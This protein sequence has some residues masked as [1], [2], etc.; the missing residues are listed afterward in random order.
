VFRPCTPT[1]N[2]LET[3]KSA[4]G[5]ILSGQPRSSAWRILARANSRL[6]SPGAEPRSGIVCVDT[7][8]SSPRAAACDRRFTLRHDTS[9]LA[10]PARRPIA[11]RSAYG[12]HTWSLESARRRL[13]STTAAASDR[14]AGIHPGRHRPRMGPGHLLTTGAVRR[15]TPSTCSKESDDIFTRSCD[16]GTP[17]AT[18]QFHWPSELLPLKPAATPCDALAPSPFPR[19][20]APANRIGDA[21]V[22]PEAFSGRVSDTVTRA[23]PGFGRCSLDL[24][25]PRHR[26]LRRRRRPRQ[27]VTSSTWSAFRATLR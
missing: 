7:R 5:C 6:V 25:L 10:R 18:L 12:G 9:K 21:N 11:V 3:G 22:D 26:S 20:S 16:S 2:A 27:K 15:R 19:E 24:S 4:F 1:S 8:P 17:Q 23:S 14:E 13:S